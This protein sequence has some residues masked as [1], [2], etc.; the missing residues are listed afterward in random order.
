[1][2]RS[3]HLGVTSVIC[4]LS[5]NELRQA[6]LRVVLRHAPLYRE[7][8][9]SEPIQQVTGSRDR[10]RIRQTVKAIEGYMM[11]SCVALGLLQLIA[12]RYSKKTPALFFRYLRTPAKRVASEATVMAYLRR[13]I[14]QR[15]ARNRHLTLT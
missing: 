9:E 8:G 4:D 10:K 2:I 6:W 15:F 11:V 7:A 13:S 5:L 3:D 12:L 1:M 14:F